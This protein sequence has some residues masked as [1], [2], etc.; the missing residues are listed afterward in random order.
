MT[1]TQIRKTILPSIISLFRL[2]YQENTIKEIT[3]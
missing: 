3:V 2:G 1:Q